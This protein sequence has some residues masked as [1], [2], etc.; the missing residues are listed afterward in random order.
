M[1][2]E[3]E[4]EL[5]KAPK[6]ATSLKKVESKEDDKEVKKPAPPP[7]RLP[8]LYPHRVIKA[9][10]NEQYDKFLEFF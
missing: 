10:Q 4:K 6:E 9:K 2:V 3:K 7:Y 8:I 5:E 1:V